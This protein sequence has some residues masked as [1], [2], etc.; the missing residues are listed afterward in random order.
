[1]LS[2]LAY[3]ALNLRALNHGVIRGGP[4]QSHLERA[5]AELFA[6]DSANLQRL[7]HCDSATYEKQW[8]GTLTTLLNHSLTC[9]V[10]KSGN[11]ATAFCNYF[12]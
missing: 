8:V 4:A 3:Y 1:V 2:K 5:E 7:W 10:D 12:R 11:F 9:P 6:A